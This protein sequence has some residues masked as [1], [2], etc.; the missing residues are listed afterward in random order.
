MGTKINI[1]VDE[2]TVK[3]LVLAHL[4]TLCGVA[5]EDTDVKIEVKS[6]QNYKSEWEVASY[7]ATVDKILL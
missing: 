5:L 1:E 4:E 7:R 3:K 2:N 6:K